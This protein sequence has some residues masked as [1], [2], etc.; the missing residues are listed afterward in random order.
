MISRT[1]RLLYMICWLFFF[2]SPLLH[3]QT[4]LTI[5]PDSLTGSVQ[6]GNKPGVFFVPKTAAAY[7]DFMGNGIYYPIIRTNIIEGA[8]NAFNDLPSTLAY[9]ESIQPNLQ[10]LSAKCETLLFIFEKMPPWLSSS[11]DSSP[12]SIPGWTVLN[13]QPPADW[14]AWHAAVA[15]ITHKIVTELGITNAAFEC[16]NE[17][18]LGSWTGSKLAWFQLYQYTYDAVKSVSPSIP[19]GGPTV[20]YQGGNLNWQTSPGAYSYAHADSSLIGEMLDSCVIWNKIPDFLSWHHF[21][22]DYRSIGYAADY[23]RY[24]TQSLG[25]PEIPMYIS[26]WN[27]PQALRDTPY[28]PAA[29][30]RALEAMKTAGIHANSVAA[31]QDFD[32]NAEEFHHDYGLITYGTIHKPAYIALQ[33]VNRL[34]G[35]YCKVHTTATTC[36]QTTSNQDTVYVLLANYAPP[37]LAETFFHTLYSGGFTAVQLDSAGYIDLSAGDLSHLDSIYRQL[38]TLPGS[39]PMQTAINASIPMFHYYDSLEHHPRSFTLELSGYT[40]DYEATQ[41]LIDSNHH[42]PQFVYDSLRVSG[43]TQQ[44]AINWVIA[45]QGMVPNAIPFTSGQ[46]TGVLHP[47]AVCLYKITI[48]GLAGLNEAAATGIRVFPNPSNGTFNVYNPG[49]IVHV[50]LTDATGKQLQQ[51]NTPSANWEFQTPEPGFYFLQ[52]ETTSGV[53]VTSVIHAE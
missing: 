41:I 35:N 1:M 43:Y 39:D 48:P 46:H 15:A 40:G 22:A 17:P 18:D 42:N 52:I 12:S 23:I 13:T 51:W 32:N 45:H 24:K 6:L 20:N 33:L 53:Y 37:A 49:N 29:M 31:W 47:N 9:L 30:L 25:I 50:Q 44:D 28:A 5:F 36:V 7:Y 14:D 38:L 3:G 16:W 11:S 19:V 34:E 10:E 8:M 26:E 4:H 21:S 27:M 2:V